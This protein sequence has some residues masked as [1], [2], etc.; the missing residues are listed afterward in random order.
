MKLIVKNFGHIKRGE[1]DLTKKLYLFVGYNNSGKTYMSQLL[2]SLF[3]SSKRDYTPTISL[4]ISEDSESI[5]ITE[6]TVNAVIEDFRNFFVE[7]LIPRHFNIKKDHFLLKDFDVKFEGD[8]YS[9]FVESESVNF[10]GS[11]NM[12]YHYFSSKNTNSNIILI[13]KKLGKT[14]GIG[15][16]IRATQ[17]GRINAIVR[18]GNNYTKI[19]SNALSNVIIDI[20]LGTQDYCPFFLPANRAFY[21]TYF[22][23]IYSAA[24]EQNDKILEQVR[25]GENLD[26]IKNILNPSYTLS[27]NELIEAIY[28]IEENPKLV[29]KYREF[30]LELMDIME[31]SVSIITSKDGPP[32]KITFEVTESKS[33]I[34]L[35]LASS[36]VNQLTGIWLFFTLWVEANNGNFL[37]LDEL[38]S[39]LH[40]KNQIKLLNLLLKFMLQNDNRLLLATHSPLITRAINNYLIL[41]SLAKDLPKE[42]IEDIAADLRIENLPLNHDE[43]GIYFFSG[44]EIKTY[45]IGE[46]GA[47]FGDFNQV[48]YAIEDASAE[49]GERLFEHLNPRV[50]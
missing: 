30:A 6:E 8:F 39:N 46:Y 7:E 16:K 48:T 40:P 38:E 37:I 20:A 5:A 50:K 1:I 22:K 17:N 35:Y 28:K 23:Y 14:M 41:G 25:R 2:W 9:R 45:E 18:E 47:M 11:L 42:E 33:T 19:L 26:E 43:V 13:E 44:S 29:T 4:D 34:D 27:V 15:E 49:L 21:P 31:G 32:K 12:D 24:K 36:S 3:K 10:I